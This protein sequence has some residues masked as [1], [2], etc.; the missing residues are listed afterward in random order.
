MINFHFSTT[1][2]SA[3]LKHWKSIV[4]KH[5]LFKISASVAEKTSQMAKR[6]KL[7]LKPRS[8]PLDQSHGRLEK[9]RLVSLFMT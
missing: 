1:W 2:L 7:N 5:K 4:Q 3:A 6:P 8:E 9:D